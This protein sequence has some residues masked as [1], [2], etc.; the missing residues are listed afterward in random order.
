M[1]KVSKRHITAFLGTTAAAAMI[2][3][4]CGS[5]AS[6]SAPSTS[7]KAVGGTAYFAEGA[8]ASPNYIFPLTPGTNFSVDNLAQFQILMYRPLYFFGVGSKAE[9]NYA[10]SI[11][12][13]PVYSN[14]N[15]T[16]TITLKNYKWSNGE[17]VTSRDVIFWMNLLKANKANWAAYVPGSFP[18]NVVSYSA[19]NAHT[20]VFNLNASYSPD[21][22]TYNELSQITPLPMAW[23]RTSLSAPAPSPT[24]ANLPDT[25]TSGAQAVYKFLNAQA[26]DLSTYA[27]SP[28][29]SIVDGPWKLQSFTTQG[30]A[31]F[32]PNSS[33]AGPVKPTLAKFVELPFTTN[34]AEFNV[35]A[36]GNNAITYGYIP[37]TDLVQKG[38]IQAAG[39][40]IAP[41][42]DFG[43]NY[44]VENYNNPTY[45]PVFKQAYFRQA[46]QHLVDQPQWIS[47]FWKGYAVPSYSPVPLAPTNPFAN[48]ATRNNLYP[49]SITTAKAL[50]TS[51]GWTVVNGVMTCT[52]PG[53][54]S[55]TCGAGVKS[56]TALNLNLQYMS[57]VTALAQEMA[58]FQSAAKQAGITVNL[59]SATFNTVITNAAPC[60]VTSTSPC[61]WQMENWGGGWEYSPDNYPSGGELFSTGSGAN[62]GSWNDPTTN[63]LIK[64]THTASNSQGALNAYQTY[65]AKVLPVIFQPANNYQ[66]SVISKKLG[67]VTQSA[68]LNLTP[69]TWYFIK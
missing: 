9:V 26:T 28:I 35:L 44:W 23:D 61:T 14:N 31:V 53:T 67:G 18:D 17:T 10:N 62:F 55:S 11:G 63:T 45:G 38:R 40:T 5:G 60:T 29:W 36:A 58:A 54:T 15:K 46:L 20:V 51:H 8:G 3:A 24:A 48:A 41:W 22:F 42:V 52:A 66:I 13:A 33:Y 21:W 43:F 37:H 32:I 39:N 2:L 64:E 59:S 57:G 19:P 12:N 34:T 25:T 65:M 69:E 1:K 16:V 47:A 68:Y 30:K 7:G 27:T 49:Y 56:G 50:L 6:T 4:A